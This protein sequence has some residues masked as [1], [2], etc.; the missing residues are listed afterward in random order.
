[1]PES[2]K[3]LSQKRAKLIADNSKL[4]ADAE[5]AGHARLTAEQDQEFER[6]EAEIKTIDEEISARQTFDRRKSSLAK[7]QE[8]SDEPIQRTTAAR[9]ERPNRDGDNNALSIKWGRLGEIQLKPGSSLYANLKPRST[10][11]YEDAFAQFLINGHKSEVLATSVGND[12]KGGVLVSSSFLSQL[13]KFID[14]DV[15][16]RRLGTVLPPTL[17]KDVGMVSFDTD[18]ADADWTAEVPASDISEDDAARWGTR[19]MLPHLLTKLVKSS[20]KLLRHA[21]GI[22]TFVAQRAAY[23]FAITENKAFLTGS[24]S[25]R[26]LGIFTASNDGVPT[27]RDTTATGTTYFT[28]DDLMNLKYSLKFQYQAKSSWVVSRTFMKN[29]RKLKYGTGEYMAGI[30]GNPDMILDRPVYVDENAP[31]TFTTGQYVAVLAD[32]SFY[33][34]QDTPDWEA[35]TLNE[36]FTLKNQTGWLFRK[37]TDAMPVLSEAFARLVLA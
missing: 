37:E 22:S 13:I 21:P 17:A 19:N 26:P 29:F 36:L 4:V 12:A 34:I 15:L 18:Y 31:S 1:M 32:M 24:G 3:E 25:Q 33:W 27:T 8:E 11:E 14:D 2:I 9:V 16:I 23:R 5:A 10:P 7:M 30:N 35:E 20:K 6:R 28:M